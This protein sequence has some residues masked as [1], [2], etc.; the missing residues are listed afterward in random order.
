MSQHFLIIAT[1]LVWNEQYKLPAVFSKLSMT[2]EDRAVEFYCSLPRGAF[3]LPAA[4]LGSH[5]ITRH[6]RWTIERTIRI[7]SAAYLQALERY[8]NGSILN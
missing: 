8:V 3:M 5:Y 2:T 7:S 6:P 4:R 1:N